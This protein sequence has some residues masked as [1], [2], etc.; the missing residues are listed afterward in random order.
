MVIKTPQGD[1]L[2]YRWINDLSYVDKAGRRWTFTAIQYEGVL[3]K[4]GKQL[5]AWLTDLK[6]NRQTVVE[7]ATKGGRQRWHIENQGFNLQ[8]N[9]EL[10]LE[11]AYCYGRQWTA[12]YYLLQIAH[13]LLQLLEKGSLLRR[14]ARQQE[15]GSAIQLFGS[16]KNM[17]RRLLESVRYTIWP[18]ESF[19][20][21][22]ARR[23]QIRLDSG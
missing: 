5:W 23:I 7:V 1:R 18:E 21:G 19:D 3:K 6:V 22:S 14:L 2:T 16:L 17:A 13:V 15:K 12:Y 8:K 10:N 9:S 11:H 20:A 4:G